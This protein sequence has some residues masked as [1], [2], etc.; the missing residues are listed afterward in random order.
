[1][2][3][4]I[5]RGLWRDR[6][7]SFLPLII[8]AS[9]VAMIV[10]MESYMRGALSEMIETNARFEA[11]H[12]KVM[13]NAYYKDSLLRPNDLAL[14][15][16]S[17]RSVA[18]KQQFPSTQWFPRIRFGGLLDVPNAN[19]ETEHQTQIA[20]LAVHLLS[21]KSDEAKN[22]RL[23][24]S[25]VRGRYPQKA[26]EV[27]LSEELFDGFG[28]R[29]GDKVTLIATGADSGIAIDNF[30]V[31]GTVQFGVAA[32]DRGYMIADYGTLSETLAMPDMASELLGFFEPSFDEAAALSI[33]TTF[34]LNQKSQGPFDPMMITLRDQGGFGEYLDLGKSMSFLMVSIFILII[35]MVLW[36]AG[37]RNGIRRYAEFGLRLAIGETPH[38]VLKTLLMEALIIGVLGSALGTCIGLIPS[39]Y[40]QEVDFQIKGMVDAQNSAIL[41]QDIIRAQITGTSFWIG[42]VPGTFSITL[43]TLIAS[44]AIFRRDTAALFKELEI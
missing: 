1:M 41:F 8:V 4:F 33:K 26:Y 9:G 21:Q 20:G 22:L 7:R 42:F 39:Y 2:I 6:S 14:D 17:E 38:H 25:M 3:G 35:S 29:L 24:D 16:I 37:V 18:L 40:L 36:N 43:G 31:V 34:N 11:G 30:M 5:L 15:Q 19:G 12:L 10:L 32:M 23:L 28:L 13:T 44:R 27:L